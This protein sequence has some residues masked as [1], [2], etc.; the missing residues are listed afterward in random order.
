MNFLIKPVGNDMAKRTAQ[1]ATREQ[2]RVHNSRL[3]LKTIYDRGQIS[4]ADVA[5]ET[6]LTPTTVS[7]VVAD[8][9]EQG[10]VEE[11]GFAPSVGGKPPM[12]LGV[13]ADSYHV[14]G[15]DLASGE[16]CGAVANLRGQIRHRI[17]LPL[18]DRDG[19]AALVGVYHLIDDLMAATDRPL[20]G[21]GLGTPGLMDPLNGIVRRAV[22]LEWH[23]LPLRDLLQK[24]YGLPVYVANDS[25]VAALAEYTFGDGP[26]VENLVVIK[27]G[28][29]IG[30]GIV[31]NGRIFHGETFGAGEIG[32]VTMVED[33]ELCRCGHL[34][35]LETLASARAIIAKAQ[36]IAS[37]DPN[38]LL[39]LHPAN[40]EAIALQTIC[41]AIDNGD[42]A[43]RQLVLEAGRYLGIAT[44]YLVAVLSARRIIIAG[45]VACFGSLLLDAI[46]HEM[47][48]RSLS[49]IAD[50]AEVGLSTIGS[51]IVSLGA[52]ALVLNR[53][54]GLFASPMLEL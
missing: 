18:P 52:S 21:I 29:G 31:L 36:A 8:L 10:L 14:I 13:A 37:Q 1:K 22:N 39:H 42:K 43:M 4:R 30:A 33:G 25:Q 49:V 50:E 40:Q 48:N 12:L 9:M 11:I 23:D 15:I 28:H 3:V 51:D 41:R 38:S 34:G 44:A 27:V 19:E 2:T 35:C 7:D 6:E 26:G 54:L 45:S 20:L 32:H 16:F 17:S 47:A 46:R 5:R 53:E 24:R